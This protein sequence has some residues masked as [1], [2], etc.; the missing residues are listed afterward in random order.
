MST[1][2]TQKRS[3]KVKIVQEPTA[4]EIEKQ[5]E[6][7]VVEEVPPPEPEIVEDPGV[8]SKESSEVPPE[9]TKSGKDQKKKAIYEELKEDLD[10][11]L[12]C[13]LQDISEAKAA[14]NKGL[15]TTL[16]S[17]E[18]ILR[19]IK[20]NMKKVEPKEKKTTVRSQP[21]GFNKPL[22][23]AKELADF[24]GWNQDD[25]KSRT[26]VTKFLCKYV[27]DNNLQNPDH[28]KT[29][30]PDDKLCKIL[31]YDRATQPLLTYSTMQKYIGH[32]FVSA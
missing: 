19:R 4:I 5:P 18:K 32:L 13:I 25:L 2:P 11:L 16:K 17:Y 15:Q 23:I 12:N 8:E 3:K 1:K 9:E 30:I 29:I 24:S 27:K 6:P 31:R 20:T 22:P 7:V 14:K 21:S 28:R 26:D 10:E